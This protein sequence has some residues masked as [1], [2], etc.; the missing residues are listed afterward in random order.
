MEAQPLQHQ[1]YDDADGRR[2]YKASELSVTME[3]YILGRFE[4]L[5]FNVIFEH[6]PWNE[7]LNVYI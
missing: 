2:I 7:P 1:N 4:N 6:N 3:P 5:A